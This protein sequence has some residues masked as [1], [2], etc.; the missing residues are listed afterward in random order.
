MFGKQQIKANSIQNRDQQIFHLSYLYV[1]LSIRPH[2]WQM[3][4]R[5]SYD[6]QQI[7]ESFAPSY[8]AAPPNRPTS[9]TSRSQKADIGLLAN[10]SILSAHGA[11]GYIGLRR[12]GAAAQNESLFLSFL[13]G[14]LLCIF[15]LRKLPSPIRD[16][17]LGDDIILIDMATAR[18]SSCFFPP[19]PAVSR[20]ALP[21]R[22]GG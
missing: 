11:G 16:P 22:K 18:D 1:V 4:N 3:E 9:C 10:I 6:R 17:N 2:N 8:E 7:F 13:A 5:L 19:R 21:M 12:C 14:R 15:R 20:V